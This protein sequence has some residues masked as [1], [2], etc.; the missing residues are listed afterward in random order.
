MT[1]SFHA[2]QGYKTAQRE[3]TSFKGIELKVF[4]KVTSALKSVDVEEL[5][6]MV[7]LAPALV[8]NA[9]LWSI[10]LVDM[11]NPENEL[12]QNL[13]NS[14]ISLAEFTQKHT[15]KVL[16]GEADHSVLVDINESIIAGLRQS[17]D[18]VAGQKILQTEAA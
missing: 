9:K 16:A 11:L 1:N 12:P 17:A 14:L 13:K 10:L 8:D 3:L 7:K 4:S 5:N 2:Q 18:F 6:G 15:L